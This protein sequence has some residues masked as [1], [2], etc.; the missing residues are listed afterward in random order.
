MPQ[1]THLKQHAQLFDLL[2]HQELNNDGSRRVS[3]QS[4][5][6]ISHA[7]ALLIQNQAAASFRAQASPKREKA[8]R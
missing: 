2:R 1:D 3:A 4:D 7:D 6:A 5:K 8:K